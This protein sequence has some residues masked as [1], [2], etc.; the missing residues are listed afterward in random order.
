MLRCEL[1]SP[2]EPTA[3]RTPAPMANT[4]P[5]THNAHHGQRST[6]L[7]IRTPRAIDS[8]AA[9]A[10]IISATSPTARGATRWMSARAMPPASSN[11]YGW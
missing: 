3:S 10:M 11:W 7:W 5:D 8:G 2:V 4:V 1:R 9:T 6:G